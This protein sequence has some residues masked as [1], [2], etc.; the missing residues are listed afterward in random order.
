MLRGP[1][2]AILLAIGWILLLPPWEDNDVQVPHARW[3][4][5]GSFDSAAD[6]EAFRAERIHAEQQRFGDP[7]MVPDLSDPAPPRSKI[8][9]VDSRCR[10]VDDVRMGGTR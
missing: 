6:C 4:R 8:S 3:Q 2:L 9:W 1:V 7:W 10:A 5:A